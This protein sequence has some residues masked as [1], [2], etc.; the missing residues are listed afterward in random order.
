MRIIKFLSRLLI[1]ILCICC[2]CNLSFADSDVSTVMSEPSSFIVRKSID[3]FNNTIATD[4]QKFDPKINV[5][6]TT[7]VPI[8]ARLGLMLMQALSTID[9]VLQMSL[10][11]FTILFLLVMYAFWVGLEAY[12]FMRESGD[13]KQVI[14]NIFKQ[15]I[16]IGIWILVLQYGPAKIFSMIVS[17][18]LALGTYLSDFIFGSVAELYDVNIP[19][20]CQAIHNYVN[21]NDTSKLLVDADTAANIMCLPSRI[22]VFFYTATKTGFQWIIHGFGHSITMVL[23]GIVSIFIFIKCIFKYAFMTLGVVVSLF[24]T[25]LM[26]PFTALAEAM[27]KNSEKNYVGQIFDGFL[28]VFKTKKLSAVLAVFINATIYFVGLS[29]VIAICA[30]LL[31]TILVTD[32]NNQFTLGSMITTLL[33]GCLVLYLAGQSDSMAKKI[34]GEIDN[35]FGKKLET[36]VKLLANKTK[37]AAITVKGWFKK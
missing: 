29:V 13:Y 5:N 8:E 12:K 32:A 6:S 18:I 24:L 16:T 27:P 11:R 15:G 37:N 26:L 2:I 31:S 28:A 1:C 3:I 35:S 7:F 10:V 34:G 21:N 22:S 4:A 9:I 25:L 30:I 14:Y 33:T 19:D 20:T 23:V 17:P 36:E